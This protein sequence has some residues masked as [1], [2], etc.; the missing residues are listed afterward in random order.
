MVFGAARRGPPLAVVRGV[1]ARGCTV[2]PFS[3]GER[4]PSPLYRVDCLRGEGGCPSPLD[5]MQPCNPC[6]HYCRK[7]P[8]E[9]WLGGRRARCGQ[10][11]CE[12]PLCWRRPR[13]E[14]SLVLLG[15]V[16]SVSE[17]CPY[18]CDFLSYIR[19]LTHRCFLWHVATAAVATIARRS[20]RRSNIAVVAVVAVV[21]TLFA[22][23]YSSVFAV[24]AV[25]TTPWGLR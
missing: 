14:G 5:C 4:P 25:V 19:F 9:P 17:S 6:V 1:S 7:T 8:P 2:A 10:V 11:C 18:V 15:G 22:R 16:V 13:A 12:L 21:A 24:V 20:L 3:E 23:V